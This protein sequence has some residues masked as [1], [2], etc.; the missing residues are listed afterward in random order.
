[1]KQQGHDNTEF[2]S[3]IAKESEWNANNNANSG[4]GHNHTQGAEISD[5]Y[6]VQAYAQGDEYGDQHA[7]QEYTGTAEQYGSQYTGQEDDQ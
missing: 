4:E 3:S 6:A 1:M 7:V 5:Y 2:Y